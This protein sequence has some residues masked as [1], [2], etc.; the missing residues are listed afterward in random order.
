MGW[1]SYSDMVNEL[2]TNSKKK[3][4]VFQKAWAGSATGVAQR[5][6]EFYTATGNP[7][8]GVLTG[9]AGTGTLMKQSVQ[10][11]GM[12]V[13]AN[14]ST[15]T[16]HLL[17]AS[18]FSPGSTV[19]PFTAYL[20]DFLEYWPAMVVT[21][22]PTT[23]SAVALSRYTDGKGVMAMVAVQSALG[24]ASPALTLTCTFDDA[25]SST[26]ILTAP[27]NSL[28]TTTFFTTNGS[29]FMPLPAGKLGVKAITSYTIASG[30]TGT[31]AFFLVK[32][33]LCISV[34][35][36]GKSE[37]SKLLMELPQIVD[38]AH[39]SWIVMPGGAMATS[40]LIGGQVSAGWG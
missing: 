30:T 8:A 14:V 32:P 18:I 15:D 25:S 7:G 22:T 39:L 28:G 40:S 4:A 29:P 31:V 3:D 13:G 27:A 24:A 33:L 6:Y 17:R 23:P 9:T 20:C 26:G 37:D 34:L 16:K 38:D 1:S 12:D 11:A 21:G 2:T 5:W 35:T 19:V 36:L 10:G